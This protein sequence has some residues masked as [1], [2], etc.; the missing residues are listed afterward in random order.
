MAKGYVLLH[1]NEIIFIILLFKTLSTQSLRPGNNMTQVLTM[2]WLHILHCNHRIRYK[3]KLCTNPSL[4]TW[5]LDSQ[6]ELFTRF[7]FPPSSKSVP[8]APG[9]VHGDGYKMN[10]LYRW[11]LINLLLSV[12]NE[13]E[14]LALKLYFQA[15]HFSM[16]KY[17]SDSNVS[18]LS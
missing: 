7:S 8:S 16:R 14:S 9:I 6:Q 10:K 4:V 13:W 2:R 5:A 17:V 18:C 1:C 12:T 3:W 15:R 11:K